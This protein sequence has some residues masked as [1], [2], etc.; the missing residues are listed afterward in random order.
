MAPKILQFM[1]MLCA[2]LESVRNYDYVPPK[3]PEGE[4]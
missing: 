2:A 4:T 3:V 1:I